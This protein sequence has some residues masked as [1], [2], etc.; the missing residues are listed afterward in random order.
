MLISKI[1]PLSLECTNEMQCMIEDLFQHLKLCFFLSLFMFLFEHWFVFFSF[2]LLSKLHQALFFF[3]V[4]FNWVEPKFQHPFVWL[5]DFLGNLL[6]ILVDMQKQCL[7]FVEK[8][9][10]HWSIN[11]KSILKY[12]IYIISSSAISW[13]FFSIFFFIFLTVCS[14]I[15]IFIILN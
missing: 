4:L 9:N 8:K 1:K 15:A 12:Y 2:I 14:S 7:V 10:E 5:V 6:Y 3:F 13:N 11:L